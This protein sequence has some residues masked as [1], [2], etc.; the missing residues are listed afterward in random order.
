ME[1]LLGFQ[2]IANSIDENAR[3]PLENAMALARRIEDGKVPTENIKG[4]C[5]KII[6][7]I[8]SAN[9]HLFMITY[10]CIGGMENYMRVKNK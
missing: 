3:I 8:F 1:K 4:V 2:H 7:N 9:S 10:P 5:K 6:E